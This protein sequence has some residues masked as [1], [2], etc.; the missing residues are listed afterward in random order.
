MSK[1]MEKVACLLAY[2]YE[3][4]FERLSG[5]ECKE[6]VLAM[7]RFDRDGEISQM[8]T[9]VS[10]Y[11]DFISADLRRNKETWNKTS[12][13]NSKIARERHAK[14]RE[15]KAEQEKL[16]EDTIYNGIPNVRPYAKDTNVC[17]RIPSVRNATKATTAEKSCDCM[18]PATNATTATK[19]T[20]ATDYDYDYEYDKDI[21]PISPKGEVSELFETFWKAYPKKQGK[22]NAVKAFGKLKADSQLFDKIMSGLNA[23]VV[24]EQWQK[25]NGQFIPLPASWLRGRRWEDELTVGLSENDP[26]ANVKKLFE[27]AQT[28]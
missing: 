6:L 28:Q 27:E 5:D 21:P 14:E 25:D 9:R 19:A 3:E 15:I 1:K 23:Q 11:F 24:S 8:S 10:N 18:R 2:T 22:Q 12:E 16:Q 7:I 13:T 20:K 17:E 26:Y 4:H